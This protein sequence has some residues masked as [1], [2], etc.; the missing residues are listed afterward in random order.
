VFFLALPARAAAPKFTKKPTAKKQGTGAVIEFAVD[1]ETDVAV[2]IENGAGKV[3]RHLAAG[4]L[5]KNAPAPLRP[6]LSQSVTWD[7]KADWGKPAGAGPFK[8]RVALGLGAKFDRVVADEKQNF[9][10]SI[11][12]LV[13]GEGGELYVLS[14]IGAHV[15]NWRSEQLV[16]LDREGN[17]LRTIMPF[18]ADIGREKL[19]KLPTIE[20]DGNLSPLVHN[21]AARSFYPGFRAGTGMGITPDGVIVMAAGGYWG[22]YGVFVNAVKTDGSIPWGDFRGPELTGKRNPSLGR[23]GLCVSSDGKW[24]YVSG[25]DKTPAVMRINLPARD[26]AEVFFGDV[27]TAGKDGSHLGGAPKG[28][29]LDGKGNLLVADPAN[30]RIVLVSERTGKLTGE[31]AFE[32][33]DRVAVD[34]G[35]GNVYLTR[36]H[37]TGVVDLVKLRSAGDATQIASMTFKPEGDRRNHWIMALDAGAKPPVVW[38]GGAA[39]TLQRVTEAGGKFT[40]KRVDTKKYL[41][42][43]FVDV[44]VDRWREDNEIY[45]RTRQSSWIRF[46]ERTGKIEPSRQGVISKG[47]CILPGPDGNIYGTEWPAGLF[48]WSREGKPIAWKNPEPGAKDFNRKYT[49]RPHGS[50]VPVCMGFMMHAHGI[51]HDNHHFVFSRLPTGP[52]RGIKALHEYDETGKRINGPIIWKA[53]DNILGPRF[54]QEGNIYVAEQVRPAGEYCPEELKGVI[55]EVKLG[56]KYSKALHT[57]KGAILTMY[58]SI[59]KFSPKGGMIEHYPGGTNRGKKVARP[60]VGEPKLDASLKSEKACWYQG[61]VWQWARPAEVTGALWMKLGISHIP[62]FY[63][64]CENTRFDVDEFGRVWYPDLGRFRV[65]VLDTNGNEIAEFGRYGNADFPV[66]AGGAD[67]PFAWLIGVGVTDKY[68]YTGDSINKRLQRAKIVYAAEESCPV[69]P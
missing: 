2:F 26:K 65:C 51:R 23:S 6:G 58:G 53:S 10:Y 43:G 31:F 59:L 49:P 57:P 56:S 22:A 44:Q 21:V 37:K 48:K 17:Y 40:S 54:D 13:V 63:C 18:P 34:A 32:S 55:G 41:H 30:N 16:A 42:A 47:L 39:G 14:A 9:G 3:V 7:G 15:P 45:A 11:K 28:L 19:G 8:V 69:G 35:T 68:V 64:N 4:V 12:G 20:L 5:G 36:A 29:A 62:L 61:G 60:F 52:Y 67:I 27:K 38:M 24:V 66:Q 50:F 25:W 33:P 1:R 46:S